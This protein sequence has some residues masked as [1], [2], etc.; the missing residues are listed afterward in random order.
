MGVASSDAGALASETVVSDELLG[1]VLTSRGASRRTIFNGTWPPWA[2]PDKS[3]VSAAD[4]V[5]PTTTNVV[6]N[7]SLA[8]AMPPVIRNVIENRTVVRRM[9]REAKRVL[10]IGLTSLC[11]T[12]LWTPC[13]TAPQTPPRHHPSSVFLVEADRRGEPVRTDHP[14]SSS[15]RL[16]RRLNPHGR[17]RGVLV[18]PRRDDR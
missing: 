13:P 18:R 11:V 8:K 5:C 15:A 7:S 16:V 14:I 3:A 1:S 10:N 4:S 17:K 9:A 2:A 6:R 12:C